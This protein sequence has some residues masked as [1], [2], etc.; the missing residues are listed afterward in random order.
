M[1]PHSPDSKRFSSSSSVNFRV[2]FD[3]LPLSCFTRFFLFATNTSLERENSP[4]L[5]MLNGSFFSPRYCWILF[6]KL[7][8]LSGSYSQPSCLRMSRKKRQRNLSS[9]LAG[10]L[11]TSNFPLY[12]F[13][14]AECFKFFPIILCL[15]DC[16][17]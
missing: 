14:V 15:Y 11:F 17:F 10:M 4:S 6:W 2:A 13:L 7:L 3:L 16:I 9:S 1:S 12:F 8:R 5:R